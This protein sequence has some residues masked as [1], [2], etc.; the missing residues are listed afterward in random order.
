M[1]EAYIYFFQGNILALPEKHSHMVTGITA[2]L[3][4][5]S[6]CQ[7][8]VPPIVKLQSVISNILNPV[9]VLEHMV[10][11]PPGLSYSCI[12]NLSRFR[13]IYRVAP[14]GLSCVRAF[15]T[16][17]GKRIPFNTV[18]IALRHIEHRRIAFHGFHCDIKHRR[19]SEIKFKI[20]EF[21]ILAVNRGIR[22]HRSMKHKKR[23][24]SLKRHILHIFKQETNFFHFII[25]VGPYRVRHIEFFLK[26]LVRVNLILAFR[27]VQDD[28]PLHLLCRRN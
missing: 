26:C 19:Y 4:T 5:V 20:V 17:P 6:R 7:Y 14:I 16:A 10:V 15:V 28:R 8:G 3:V 25:L 18:V 11:I 21:D 1:H 22:R 27:K 9:H 13:I 2:D 24:I 12:V 23:T